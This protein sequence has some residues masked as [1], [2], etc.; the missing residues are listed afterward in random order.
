MDLLTD[1][2]GKL[3]DVVRDWYVDRFLS[4]TCT[5][6]WLFWDTPN[7]VVIIIEKQKKHESHRDLTIRREITKNHTRLGNYLRNHDTR[8]T[9]IKPVNYQ[10]QKTP[11]RSTYRTGKNSAI[12]HTKLLQ[13]WKVELGKWNWTF[14]D[15]ENGGWS[16]TRVGCVDNQ[17]FFFFTDWQ[18]V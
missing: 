8:R 9:T 11:K 1:H 18:I 15:R 5:C 4:V 17:F 16:S 13:P 3:S 10:E 14:A 12:F 2:V 6:C 7:L